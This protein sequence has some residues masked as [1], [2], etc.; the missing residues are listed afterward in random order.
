MDEKSMFGAVMEKTP[1]G[2]GSLLGGGGVTVAAIIIALAQTGF[3]APSDNKVQQI[4]LLQSYVKLVDQMD[5]MYDWHNVEDADG[6]KRW[7]FPPS[8]ARQLGEL[9]EV[10]K[11]QNEILRDVLRELRKP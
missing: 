10:N 6:V 8:Y 4:E 1:G 5:D 11:E 2:A 3:I 7:W 9:M